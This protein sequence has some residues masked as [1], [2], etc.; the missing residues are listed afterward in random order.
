[1]TEIVGNAMLNQNTGALT[2]GAPMQLSMSGTGVLVMAGVNSYT[3]GTTVSGGTLGFASPEA[4]PTTGI[5]NVGRSGNISL[6]GLLAASGAAAPADSGLGSDATAAEPDASSAS[7]V[8]TEATASDG[9]AAATLGSVGSIAG[10]TGTG[11]LT[12]APAAVPEPGTMALLLAA[13]A[14]LAVAAWKRRK[15]AR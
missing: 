5:L 2:G 11:G 9:P 4:V 1:V 14:G 12:G 15:L 6:V 13:T 8:V 10:V 7:D 3:G